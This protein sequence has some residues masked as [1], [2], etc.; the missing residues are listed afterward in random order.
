MKILLALA[1]AACKEDQQARQR[2]RQAL[3]QAR[4]E[5]LIR[6]F[7]SEREPLARLLRQLVPMLQE[8]VLRSY[9]QTILRAFAIP[10]GE[11]PLNTASSDGLLFQPPFRARTTCVA[12]AHCRGSNSEIAQELVVSVNAVQ[13]GLQG[14][15]ATVCEEKVDE[16][17][18][19]PGFTG[20]LRFSSLR[21][22]DIMSMDCQPVHL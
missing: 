4:S 3:S 9:A 18:T 14:Y 10:Y 12:I 8:P 17:S 5:G 11:G 19:V 15:R 22:H 16:E 13:Y 20:Q 1:H 2:L 21:N 6:P 7:L